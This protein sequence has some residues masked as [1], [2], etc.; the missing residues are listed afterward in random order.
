MTEPA[1]T[2]RYLRPTWFTH[3]VLNRAIR[4][5]ARIGLSPKGLR[6]LQVRGRTSG[7]LRTTAVN[8]LEVDGR[9]YLVAPRGRTQWVRNLRAAGEGQ[10]RVGR[11]VE[12]ITAR[13]LA[14]AEKLPV[15][16]QYLVR[17]RSEV[18]VFFEGLDVDA[19]DEQLTAIAPGFPAFEVVPAPPAPG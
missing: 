2:D 1:A 14:D 12:A 16:R 11:R 8:L 15:L 4:R 19:T 6:E 13:E 3:H 5:L 10:L 17:W 18:K 7:E 9:R